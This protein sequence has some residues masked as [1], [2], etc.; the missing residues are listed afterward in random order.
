M[1]KIIIAFSHDYE[2]NLANSLMSML[3]PHLETK[4]QFYFHTLLTLLT[5][6]NSRRHLSLLMAAQNSNFFSCLENTYIYREPEPNVLQK[7]KVLCQFTQA[8]LEIMCKRVT[9][10]LPVSC[11]NP[12]VSGSMRNSLTLLSESVSDSWGSQWQR[13]GSS[14]AVAV[15]CVSESQ[16]GKMQYFLAR[17]SDSV[18]LTIL[19]FL[20]DLGHYSFYMALTS[21]SSNSFKQLII[22]LINYLHEK[23][24]VGFPLRTLADR[25]CLCFGSLPH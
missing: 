6:V 12:I 23:V 3:C 10:V 13:S 1:Y 4:V 7:L 20:C 14:G 15:Y 19:V 8:L 25:M 22:A 16:E 24:I 21:L 9:Q 17:D 18:V 2:N 11:T 5:L